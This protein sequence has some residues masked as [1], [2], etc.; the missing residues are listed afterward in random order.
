V[1]VAQRTRWRKPEARSRLGSEVPDIAPYLVPP[2][3]EHP[4]LA[5]SARRPFRDL[6]EYPSTVDRKSHR[7]QARKVPIAQ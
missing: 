1:A 6:L 4:H 5:R 2:A 7:R 3:A